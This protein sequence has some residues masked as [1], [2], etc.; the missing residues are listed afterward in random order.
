MRALTFTYHGVTRSVRGWTR[1]QGIAIK[2][3][4]AR[5]WQW[6][7]SLAEALELVERPPS[8]LGRHKLA[9]ALPLPETFR[10]LYWCPQHQLAWRHTGWYPLPANLLTFV[11]DYCKPCGHASLLEVVER[12]CPQCNTQ[13]EAA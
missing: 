8:P 7:W 6:G 9:R 11:R 4:Y 1:H 10:V 3:V 5:Y 13:Q 2:T 12:R